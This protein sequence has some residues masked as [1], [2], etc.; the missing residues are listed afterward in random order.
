MFTIISPHQSA[1]VSGCL[2]LDNSMVVAEIDH[3][4]HNK[5]VGIDDFLALK[6]DLSK[7]YDKVEWMFLETMMF[8]TRFDRK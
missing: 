5:R 8:K 4:L 7:A 3:Y 2:I 6:L 1:L